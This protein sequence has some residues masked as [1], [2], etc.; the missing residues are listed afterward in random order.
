MT[1]TITEDAGYADSKSK[2]PYMPPP[3][4]LRDIADQIEDGCTSGADYP[5]GWGWP[6]E[7]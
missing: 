7:D 6:L 2:A 3:D 1:L 5:E 4:V